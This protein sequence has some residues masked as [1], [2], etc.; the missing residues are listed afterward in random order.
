MCLAIPGKIV[1]LYE[2]GGLKMGRVDF[3]GALREVCLEYVPEAVVGDYAVV[4]VGF[5]LNLVSP[6][7]AEETLKLLHEMQ[8]L[9]S[10]LGL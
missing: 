2:S 10:E 7:E 9:G 8:D 6:S 3:G 5:A 4:H 1:E